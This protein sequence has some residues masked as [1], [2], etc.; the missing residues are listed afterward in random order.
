MTISHDPKK[1]RK[2]KMTEQVAV[3]H[4][5]EARLLTTE[6]QLARGIN[7]EAA[8]GELLR[9]ARPQFGAGDELC[10]DIERMLIETRS[11][12]VT[13]EETWHAYQ[14]LLERARNTLPEDHRIMGSLAR[15]TI[16]Y[17]RYAGD[18]DWRDAYQDDITRNEER[19]GTNSRKAS[20]SRNNLASALNEYGATDEDR[21]ES[22]RIAMKEWTWRKAEFT[23][24]NPFCFPPLS[25][26]VNAALRA[27]RAGKPLLD[28]S[29]LLKYARLIYDRRLQLLGG[30]HPDTFLSL[31]RLQEVRA[32]LG[33][34]DARWQLLSILDELQSAGIIVGF[35]E[36]LPIAICRAFSLS[37]D[38]A[39]AQEW[40]VTSRNL[41]NSTYGSGS[42][43][44]TGAIAFLQQGIPPAVDGTEFNGTIRSAH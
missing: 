25:N 33:E 27:L 15:R 10:L 3:R 2:T 26:A 11:R 22:F 1:A 18:P 14:M 41:L 39:S 6:R 13:A 4:R 37:G 21:A 12:T 17:G 16:R 32:E 44:A 19:Y 8:L 36:S 35:R 9:G 28:S 34:R 20:E 38:H 7:E 23:D 30:S 43:R 29:L 24:Q 40:F 42:P 31:I 5:L